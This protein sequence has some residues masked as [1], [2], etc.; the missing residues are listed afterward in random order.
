NFE[1]SA[2]EVGRA[3]VA[4]DGTL[5]VTLELA[6]AGERTGDEVVQLYLRPMDVDPGR[7]LKELRG[8]KRVT[9]RPAERRSITFEVQPSRDLRHFDVERD[10]YV[11]NPGRYE[12]EVGASSTDIRLKGTFTVTR[13]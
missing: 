4:V 6:N 9:L 13:D 1:Y 2:L 10:R 12:V 8:L 5:E 11:T 7:S 3:E